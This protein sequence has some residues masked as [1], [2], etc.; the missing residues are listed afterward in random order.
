MPRWPDKKE[1]ENSSV[2]DV[3]ATLE[4]TSSEW[5]DALHERMD[6]ITLTFA[7]LERRLQS[8]QLLEGVLKAANPDGVPTPIVRRRDE[9]ELRRALKTLASAQVR[10]K[11]DESEQIISDC[12]GEL[13][14]MRQLNHDLMQSL[15]TAY[16][17][18]LASVRKLTER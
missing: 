14:A 4:V 9:I 17:H 5:L 10:P 13:F 3:V 18:G 15:T 12:I 11:D 1:E 16:Q 6:K 8:V 7:D 2:A